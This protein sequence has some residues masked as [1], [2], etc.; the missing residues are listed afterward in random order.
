[1]PPSSKPW[2]LLVEDDPIFSL[3]FCR[4]WKA[5]GCCVELCL[6]KSLAEMERALTQ[7][8]GPPSLV[9][10]DRNLPDGDGHARADSADWPSHCWSSTSEGTSAA[11]P[12]GK[13]ALQLAV[14]HLQEKVTGS[15]SAC[16]PS[17]GRA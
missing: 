8:D 4:F 9:I 15:L 5:S 10:L 13:Q 12:R 1:M 7:A 3:L 11:K 2:V 16:P 17:E 14:A 6:A